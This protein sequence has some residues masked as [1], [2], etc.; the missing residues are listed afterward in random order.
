MMPAVSTSHGRSSRAH[1]N[2]SRTVR[3][4][5]V[6]ALALLAGCSAGGADDPTARGAVPADPTAK[7]VHCPAATVTVDTADTLRAA[8]TAAA[9]GTVID[10]A[11]ATYDGEFVVTAAGTTQAPIWLC[12]GRN[13]VLN[14]PGIGTGVV[15]HLTGSANWRLVGFTVMRGQKGVLADRV[16]GSIFQDLAVSQIGDEAVHLRTGST[17]NVVRGLTITGTGLRSQKFGEGI[18]VGSA[19]SNWC[20]ISSC[21]PDRSDGNVVAGNTIT[22]TTAEAV[23]VK[24]GTSGGVLR[25]NV[26]NGSGLRGDADSW[27]D[28]KGNNWLIYGN[29][30][31]SSPVS[32]FQTHTVAPGWGTG[33]V[34]DANIADVQG[35]GYGFELRPVN[36]NRVTCSNVAIGAGKGLTNTTCR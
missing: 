32:G 15:L 4:L 5:L 14:G 35:P 29:R 28:I 17:A 33:N 21:Q 10:L 19:V 16:T 11:D 31:T 25:D 20:E 8:L 7:P 18:Y 23:D 36:D 30:G 12:G 24:E 26:F 34:F 22:D 13:A 27:V 9:P 1:R 2:C 6:G 3:L